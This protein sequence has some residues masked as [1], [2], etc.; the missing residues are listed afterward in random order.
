MKKHKHTKIMSHGS[1]E[2]GVADER[3]NENINDRCNNFEYIDHS[4]SNSTWVIPV[5]M[6]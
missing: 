3:V 1:Q 4:I 5:T 2:W 6:G